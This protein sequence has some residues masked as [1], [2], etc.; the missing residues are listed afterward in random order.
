[1]AERRVT[2]FNLYG[3]PALWLLASATTA[4]A[5][6]VVARL[7]EV[8]RAD[9]YT[10]WDAARWYREGVD[11]YFGHVLREG[12]GYN[13]N[14]PT[15]LL[16]FLPFSYLPLRS[17]FI[18]WFLLG[19][20]AYLVAARSISRALTI[21]STVLVLCGLLI[22][23][24]SFAAFQLGQ[25]TPFLLP[26]FTAAWLMDRADRRWPSGILLGVLV[27]LKP[28]LGV[29]GVYAIAVRRSAPMAA[30]MVAG[31]LAIWLI[32]LPLGG[33]AVYE[34]WVRALQQSPPASHLANASL[35]AAV[36]RALTTPPGALSIAPLVVAPGWVNPI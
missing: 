30:G 35:L 15:L 32:G 12:S 24:A 10:F 31:A 2:A 14:P 6:A 36:S 5:L 25:M 8:S 29:F 1:M 17:A 7:P 22:S 9:F 28:F 18:V 21:G 33:L 19:L 11:P 26:I 13:L 34:S 23:Q 3:E 27:A 16:W 4:V 20:A